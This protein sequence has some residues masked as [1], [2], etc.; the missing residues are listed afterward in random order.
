MS[1]TNVRYILV[2]IPLSFHLVLI[3]NKNLYLI[4][5]IS[6]FL[7][8]FTPASTLE[9]CFLNPGLN[10]YLC[11]LLI[12]LGVIISYLN[13]HS[14]Q[15]SFK[16]KRRAENIT[17]FFQR[18]SQFSW[19]CWIIHLCEFRGPDVESLYRRACFR[20]VCSILFICLLSWPQ[21]IKRK[22]LLICNA[23]HLAQQVS[24]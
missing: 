11:F 14:I 12:Y 18:V 8:G 9:S 16:N 21:V 20:T 1:F 17:F 15:S 22:S 4:R 10:I 13:L 6:I 2:K 24:F 3:Y 23:L 5:P 19:L 7:Y